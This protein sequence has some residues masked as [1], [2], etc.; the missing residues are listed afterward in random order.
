MKIYSDILI[1]QL[2]H[3]YIHLQRQS[4]GGGYQQRLL[5]SQVDYIRKRIVA[6]SNHTYTNE[7]I[8]IMVKVRLHILVG[9]N[10]TTPLTLATVLYVCMYICMYVCMWIQNKIGLNTAATTEYTSAMENLERKRVHNIIFHTY[11]HTYIH[12]YLHIYVRTYIY[13]N[14]VQTIKPVQP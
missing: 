5:K 4:E 2:P 14:C 11:I 9:D 12:T 10:L 3:T 6:A 1:T 7:E 8:Q 13:T